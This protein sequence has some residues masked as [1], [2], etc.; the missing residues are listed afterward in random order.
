MLFSGSNNTHP[1]PEHIRKEVYYDDQE[2]IQ[3]N[4]RDLQMQELLLTR[5]R[6]NG[7]KW[8]QM[9]APSGCTK[10]KSSAG[11]AELFS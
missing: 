1:E 3:E 10:E 8:Y 7:I 4:C 6:K 9:N 2:G 5:K 11:P